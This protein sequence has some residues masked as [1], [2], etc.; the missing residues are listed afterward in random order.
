MLSHD[1]KSHR[2]PPKMLKP[3]CGLVPGGDG[4]TAGAVTN[5]HCRMA[6]CAVAA[7]EHRQLLALGPLCSCVA[8]QR[9]HGGR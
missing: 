5:R 2:R 8:F 4:L 7:V 3:C 1:L 9:R 6:W